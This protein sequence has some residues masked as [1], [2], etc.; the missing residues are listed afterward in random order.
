[1]HLAVDLHS[2]SGYAGGVGTISLE[3]VSKTMKMKGINVFG[4]GDVLLPQRYG[5]LEELLIDLG[6]GLFK[7]TKDD[8]SYFLLQTEVI[9]TVKLEGYKHKIIA[10]HIILFPDF[11]SV[12]KCAELM[13]KWGQKNTI[14]R[15]FIVSENRD[16]MISR[17][18]EIIAIH[19]EIEIIPAH[20]MTPDGVMGCKNMLHDIEEF[21]GEFM[22]HIH[23][24]ETGLSA[25]PQLLEQIPKIAD[26]TFIS[27]SDCHSSAYNR[28]GREFTILEVQEESY[29]QII[30]AIRENRVVL[31]A[32]F[33]PAEGRYY[34]TGHASKRH[35]NKEVYLIQPHSS[36][37]L[38]CPICN[39]KMTL[40]VLD[41]VNQLKDIKIVPKK[42]KAI[43]L[44][45]LVEVISNSLNLKT[46]TSRKVTK[47]Y[48]E[49]IRHFSSE[50]RLW[51]SN[52]D[53]INRTLS[54]KI[55]NETLESIL[56]VKNEEFEFSPPGFDGEY[57]N[58]II[59]KK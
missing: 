31:T 36:E 49:I 32:E 42:R 29:S 8:P 21:Y 16:E 5:E 59:N 39:K 56:A 23:A 20:I 24:V 38:I 37:D 53:E 51:L 7:L 18:K 4:T 19:P 9:F 34:K 47:I 52:I 1:M 10:H 45:P 35:Q 41:R 11:P 57:G 50:I 43:H 17:M 6:N 13:D 14:G 54:N 58:L 26:L 48:E 2:H 46:V 30:K 15:P 12:K 22:G 3:D 28:I 55:P 40:G 33:N 25:D 27:N 44:I